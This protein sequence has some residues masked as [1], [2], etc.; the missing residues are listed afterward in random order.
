MNSFTHYIHKLGLSS[1]FLLALPCAAQAQGRALSLQ[2]ALDVALTQNP[3]R[4][5][6]ILAVKQAEAGAREQQARFDVSVFSSF[7]YEK[8][9]SSTQGTQN[10][11]AT[12]SSRGRFELG[13]QKT[14]ALGGSIQLSVGVVRSRNAIALPSPTG[15]SEVEVQEYFV[16]PRFS[17]RQ[18]LL[19]K[20]GFK[21]SRAPIKKARAMVQ[22][23]Q[24]AKEDQRRSVTRDITLSYWD[25]K[26]AQLNLEACEKAKSLIQQQIET[27]KVLIAEGRRAPRD[28]LALEQELRV[29]DIE[30]ESARTRLQ[31]QG[32]DLQL[33]MGIPMQEQ[34]LTGL[35]ATEPL[36][37]P[38]R[39]DA[40]RARDI[41]RS[42]RANPQLAAIRSRIKGLRNDLLV[43][44]NQRKPVLDAFV[45]AGT[46]GLSRDE[47]SDPTTH[48]PGSWKQALGNFFDKGKPP[49]LVDY[50]LEAGLELKW[51]PRNRSA[52][53]RFEQAKLELDAVT[54]ELA[55]TRQQLL[56]QFRKL[57]K[58][59]ASLLARWSLAKDSVNL[60][61]ENLQVER[62]RFTAGYATNDDLL[63]RIN[64]L[65]Q[66]KRRLGDIQIDWIKSQAQL[67]AILQTRSIEARQY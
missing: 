44:E 23:A 14:L 47:R 62:S 64:E 35:R 50:S 33:L 15:T 66:A 57:E 38:H 4:K 63:L 61:Q 19:Q 2:D 54:L 46:R 8:G 26:A 6:S 39:F 27:T 18:P 58:L 21:V 31:N 53:A 43:A 37:D 9:A 49:G 48:K 1:F 65:Y 22:S 25:L 42:L 59:R 3:A 40:L 24:A 51:S 34:E 7:R 67:Q 60:A 52:R 12:G 13:A 41:E 11:L 32:T 55:N 28:L 36:Q 17:F 30:L 20:A 5:A 29:K 56:G 45:S 16:Q 10:M